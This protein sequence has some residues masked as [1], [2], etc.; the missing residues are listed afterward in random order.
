MD[1]SGGYSESP[2]S[3]FHLR[4]QCDNLSTSDG[5]WSGS[6]LPESRPR[7]GWQR[8]YRFPGDPKRFAAITRVNPNPSSSTFLMR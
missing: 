2:G 6:N 5:F 3:S 4:V 7:G 8:G 1:G